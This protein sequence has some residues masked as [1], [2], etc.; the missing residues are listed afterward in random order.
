MIPYEKGSTFLWYLEQLVG[1]GETFEPFLRS[2]YDKFKFKSITSDMFKVKLLLLVLVQIHHPD[3][4]R[5]I[6]ETFTSVLG[7]SA[8][9][10]ICRRF[11]QLYYL[12][13]LRS[14]NNGT[15]T[16]L[17]CC[18]ITSLSTS[19][20]LK[21]SRRLTGR[22]GSTQRA[23]HLSRCVFVLFSLYCVF[24]LTLLLQPIFSLSFIYIFLFLHKSHRCYHDIVLARV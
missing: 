3:M 11:S 10:F 18:R 2:Y 23:C 5:A 1:G 21:P 15:L 14:K 7:L 13:F 22:L 24:P 19:L 4:L 17:F 8:S 20:V 6:A 16:T 12:H 9:F